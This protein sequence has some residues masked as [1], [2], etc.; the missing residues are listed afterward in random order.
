MARL[1]LKRDTIKAPAPAE[2]ARFVQIAIAVDD[3]NIHL[4]ALDAAGGV[5]WRDFDRGWR[6]CTTERLD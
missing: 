3:I 1:R 6:R 2:P 4:Y 5:W